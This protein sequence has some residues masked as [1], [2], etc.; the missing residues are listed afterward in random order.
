VRLSPNA[1]N[2]VVEQMETEEQIVARL[3]AEALSKHTEALRPRHK[4]APD[5]FYNA[6][7]TIDTRP[8]WQGQLMDAASPQHGCGDWDG[9]RAVDHNFFKP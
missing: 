1:V 6:D 5:V 4:S 3:H 7:G 9:S 8:R 2:K